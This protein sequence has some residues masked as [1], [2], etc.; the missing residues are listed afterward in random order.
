MFRPGARIALLT[1]VAL[2]CAV[3][4]LTIQVQADW[5]FV[6]QY[7]GAKLAA[8]VLVAYAVGISTVLFHSITHNRILTPAIMGFDALYLLIQTALAYVFGMQVVSTF[9]P[10]WKFAG[11]TGVMVLM[12][13][14]L[15][16][17]LFSG[18]VR[19]LHLMLL[20]GV[21]LGVLFRAL[22]GLM[23]R[24]IDPNEFGS[25]QDRFFASFNLIAI[26]LLATSAIALVV[27]TAF[28]WRIRFSFD[29]VALGRDIAINLGV[30][31]SKRVMQILFCI[32]VLVSVSTALVG[33]VT[34]LGLLVSNLAYQWMGNMRHRY[35][36]PAA[37]LL[38]VIAL[39]GGQLVLEHVLGYNSALS[40]VIEFVGGLVFL[41]LLLRGKGH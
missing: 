9:N 36:L 21:V 31:Y 4:F 2:L 13:F 5:A 18:A 20:V 17:T 30:D 41:L 39:V 33:P 6:L 34:F 28:L 32:A 16:R 29:V 1:G 25:L 35:T 8:M 12:A 3:V 15:F 38:G 10:A 23:L 22:T 27:V 37:V 24:L 19:S 7:R 40:M 26:D 14:I 11:E